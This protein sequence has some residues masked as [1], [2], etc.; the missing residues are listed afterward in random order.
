MPNKSYPWLIVL[1]VVVAD[2]AI[3]VW[4]KT[5]L[6]YGEEIRILGQDW[7]L[8]HFV[9]N[10]G[11]A[12]GIAPGGAVGKLALSLFRLFAVGFLSY[13]IYRLL[14]A[15]VRRPLLLGGFALILGGAIGNIIDSL[16]YGLLFSASSYH[17]GVA[18][19][20]PEEGG[21]APLFYGRVV[22]MFYFPIAYGLY[23]DWVPLLGGQSYVFFRPVFNL[24]DVAISL[25]VVLLLWA[26]Y[27][28][29]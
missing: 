13:Y 4:V 29:A 17:G 23:P 1:T 25:G 24:A 27:R 11:M 9:E 20:L 7:A 21:Y 12:F 26:F 14:E 2:Q 5:H 22:D 3:K 16:F 8:I 28:N 10:N 18:T 19:F 6:A 15:H